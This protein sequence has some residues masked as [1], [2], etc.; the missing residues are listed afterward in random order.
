MAELGAV[1]SLHRQL[2]IIIDARQPLLCLAR[3]LLAR[4][5]AMT[6]IPHQVYM[7]RAEYLYPLL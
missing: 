5:L 7:G 4:W 6:S 3:L 2:L 1:S